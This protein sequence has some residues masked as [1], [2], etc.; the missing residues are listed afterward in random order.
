MIELVLWSFAVA[1]VPM[2]LDL[3]TRILAATAE[4]FRWTSDRMT[5]RAQNGWLT[6]RCNPTT[7]GT[8]G[9]VKHGH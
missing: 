5:K 3:G 9:A 7:I 2:I 4:I 1:L 8:L 6:I